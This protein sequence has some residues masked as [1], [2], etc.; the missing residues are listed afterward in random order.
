MNVVCVD[1]S[2]YPE[3]QVGKVY[4][5]R[6]VFFLSE[7]NNEITEFEWEKNYLNLEGYTDIDWFKKD[8][9]IKMDKWRDSRL[10]QLIN[11]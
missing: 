3:L 5:A 6:V 1:N 2:I 4:K 11:Q 10:N 7:G 9:F 8:Y